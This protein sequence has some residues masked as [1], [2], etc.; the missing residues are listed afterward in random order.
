MQRNQEPT[1]PGRRNERHSTAWGK[2]LSLA[3]VLFSGVMVGQQTVASPR[4]MNASDRLHPE[5]ARIMSRLR[6]IRANW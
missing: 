2:R 3:V 1:T 5:V 6:R 4:A